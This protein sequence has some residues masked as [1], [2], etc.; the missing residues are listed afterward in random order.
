M[1]PCF[2]G[3]DMSTIGEL[4]APKFIKKLQSNGTFEKS[5]LEAMAKSIG[6]DT[7][8][9]NSISGMVK[10]IGIP[11]ENL[12]TACLDRVYPT[13]YGRKLFKKSLIRLDSKAGERVY[14]QSD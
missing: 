12:C 9:Y 5:A 14:E 13:A 3:I 2:Y 6:A 10:S 11:H 7:I 1:G 8:I 4:W